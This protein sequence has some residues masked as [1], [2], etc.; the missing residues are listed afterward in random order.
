MIKWTATGVPLG[1]SWLSS[2]PLGPP[3]SIVIVFRGEKTSACK[4][5]S[6][7]ITEAF[8]LHS[9]DEDSRSNGR[10]WACTFASFWVE[11][12]N[13]SLPDPS[14][15][16]G[17]RPL[18]RFG[19][20]SARHRPRFLRPRIHCSLKHLLT[21]LHHYINFRCDRAGSQYKPPSSVWGWRSSTRA[22]RSDSHCFVLNSRVPCFLGAVKPMEPFSEAGHG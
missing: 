18:S 17:P 16:S 4:A 8:H 2:W 19:S 10:P 9:S 14:T 5:P 7:P 3:V 21:D 22:R 11:R 1:E 12:Q 13:Q 6:T 20:C 15:P